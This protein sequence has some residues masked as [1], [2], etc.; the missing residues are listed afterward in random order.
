MVKQFVDDKDGYLFETPIVEHLQILLVGISTRYIYRR[1]DS[2]RNSL[3][4]ALAR[5]MTDDFVEELESI[6]RLMCEMCKKVE[7][8]NS[9]LNRWLAIWHQWLYYIPSSQKNGVFSN[10]ELAYVFSNV[11]TLI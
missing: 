6:T 10:H 7:P 11:L 5:D 2:I 8:S 4:Q 3:V 9:L 1:F